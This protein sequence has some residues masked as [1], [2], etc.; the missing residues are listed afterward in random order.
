MIR[1]IA[2]AILDTV[3]ETL[4]TAV[5]SVS[6]LAQAFVEKNR[7]KAKLNRLRLVM[8]SES[9]LMNRAYIALGKQYYETHK[10]G[11]E[12]PA[13]NQKQ[14][15]SV[16][17]KS[18]AKIAKAR[19]CYEHIVDSQNEY[20]YNNIKNEAADFNDEKVVDITVACSNESDYQSLPFEEPASASNESEAQTEGEAPEEELF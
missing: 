11:E 14:L 9:E 4:G 15:F 3:K 10:K 19:S 16:I 13:E 8:K 5:D 2:M 18:K 7:T 20:I 1:R 12:M 6:D 17:E